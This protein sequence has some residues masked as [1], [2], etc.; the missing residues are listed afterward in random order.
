M[1]TYLLFLTDL[2]QY[3]R[4]LPIAVHFLLVLVRGEEANHTSRNNHTQIHQ[5][6]PQL[7]NLARFKGELRSEGDEMLLT[8]FSLSRV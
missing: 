8:I 5:R 7:L 3:S 1:C 6:T 4:P 2:V